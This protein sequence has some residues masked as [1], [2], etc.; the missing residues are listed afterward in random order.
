MYAYCLLDDLSCV[1]LGI[2]SNYCILKKSY[3]KTLSEE[4]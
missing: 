3:G 4:V 1:G 2:A